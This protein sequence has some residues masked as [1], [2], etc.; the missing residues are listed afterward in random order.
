[1]SRNTIILDAVVITGVILMLVALVAWAIGNVK[2]KT[3][4][5]EEQADERMI[6]R[7]FNTATYVMDVEC[8]RA[9]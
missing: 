2:A 8:R 9:K 5:C 4:P 3:E 1:M 7:E 6:P